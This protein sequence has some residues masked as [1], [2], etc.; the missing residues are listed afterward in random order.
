MDKP[1]P[2]CGPKGKTVKLT[3]VAHR[4]LIEEGKNIVESVNEFAFSLQKLY[5]VLG[6]LGND[7]FVR[8][9]W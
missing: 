8:S 1:P 3:P 2:V 6:N 9:Y 5:Q 7:D 4:R